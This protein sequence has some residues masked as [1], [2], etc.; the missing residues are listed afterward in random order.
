MCV[1]VSASYMIE[2]KQTIEVLRG[3]TTWK[4]GNLKLGRAGR[5]YNNF[6]SSLRLLYTLF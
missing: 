3:G 6:L 2:L 1:H 5:S 4:R